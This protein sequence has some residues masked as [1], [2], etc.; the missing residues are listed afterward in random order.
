MEGFVAVELFPFFFLGGGGG[1]EPYTLNPEGL[2]LVFFFL[3]GGGG[4]GVEG[5]GAAQFELRVEFL[6]PLRTFSTWA[7]NDIHYY[8]LISLLLMIEI[9]HYLKD[10]KL[11]EL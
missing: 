11:W 4:E 2:S 1:V 5:K 6:E 8:S 9:L 7:R 3:G 10:P